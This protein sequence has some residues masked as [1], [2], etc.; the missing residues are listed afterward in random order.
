MPKLFNL[1]TNRQGLIVYG[2]ESSSD[3]GIVVSEAPAFDAPARKQTVYN[4]AGRNGAVVFQEDA[5]EDVVRS[6]NVWT[7]FDLDSLA[8]KVSAF[9]AL[10][11]SKK[12]WQRLEDSFEPEH[13]RF[14]YYQ[15]GD[16][17]S[18]TMMSYGAAT[19]NFVCRPERFLKSGE[20]P[21]SVTNGDDIVNPT[22]FTS[23]PLIKI[24]VPSSGTVTV[25]CGG[26]TISADVTDYMYIDCDA[27]NAYRLPTENK[28]NKISGSFPI[29]PSGS[30]T[31]G[32]TGTVTSVE[33]TPRFFTI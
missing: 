23:K 1:G 7:A 12:G 31:I 22:R 15:G 3:Y 4:V 18:N 32:I 10:L 25:A 9:E 20:F 11:N 28:N 33:I 2:G 8:D 27:M 30:N 13:F 21:I 24:T 19:L 26:N 17:F 29:I 16:S 14:A 6:Y 5:W